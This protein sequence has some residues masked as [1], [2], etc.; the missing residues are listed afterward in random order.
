MSVTL[1]EATRNDMALIFNWRNNP[2]VWQGLYTQLR[3]N[4]PLKWNEHRHWWFSRHNWK[5]FIVQ[6]EEIGLRDVGYVNISQLDYWSP[7][8]AVT[9]GETTLWGKGLGKRAL[10]LAHEWLVGKGYKYAHT[11]ILN[12]NNRSI[13][14]FTSLGYVKGPKSRLGESWYYKEFP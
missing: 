5:I 4:R 13:N 10:L 6:V 14:L 2:L 3:E 12:N 11:T 9:I 1:R 8:I 7:E